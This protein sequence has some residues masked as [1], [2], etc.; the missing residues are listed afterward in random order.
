[1]KK[2]CWNCQFFSLCDVSYKKCKDWQLWDQK[3]GKTACLY[4]FGSTWLMLHKKWY[5]R[6]KK[7]TLEKRVE[8]TIENEKRKIDTVDGEN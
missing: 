8:V 7:E 1:M 5:E 4:L 2:T 6:F 3:F